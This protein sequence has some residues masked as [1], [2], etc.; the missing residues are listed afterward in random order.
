MSSISGERSRAACRRTF[1]AT[2]RSSRRTS[3]A[4]S[5]TRRVSGHSAARARP[6]QGA[7][8]AGA[9]LARH[10]ARRRRGRDRRRPRGERGRQD[11]DPARDLEHRPPRRRDPLRRQEP[12]SAR[13]GGRRSA[14]HRPPARRPRNVRRAQRLGEPPPRRIHA[15]RARQGRLR[16]GT[17]VLPVARGA[18]Q[19]AGRH[20]QRR[21]AA[22]ARARTCLHAAAAPA[23]P[24]RALARPR[25]AARHRDLPHRQG[26]E[27]AGG[28]DGA[29]GRAERAPGAP[30]LPGGVRARG[31]PRRSLRA[32]QR[33]AGARVHPPELPGLLMVELARRF[34]ITEKRKSSVS[35]GVSPP[36]LLGLAAV[37]I[38]VVIGSISSSIFAQQ[39]VAGLAQGAIFGS[40]ALALVLIYR[41][42]EVINF[43][44][45]DLAM[46]TT[47]IAYQLTLW[48]LSYWLSFFLTLLIAFVLGAVL[49]VVFIRP[50]QH[51]IIA[52][53]IVTV[54]MFILI[55]GLVTWEWGLHELQVG[56]PF[57]NA[58]YHAG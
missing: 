14:R 18:P 39:T 46:A 7:V 50:I 54:G 31:R 22:D 19:P 44:Q 13:P 16:A 17:D 26:P 53:V 24:R 6:R 25:A 40:L 15:S 49:Q 58:V 12:R 28:T 45:G 2:R 33:A 30:A 41:A 57:G 42:T 3:A 4:S 47:Y 56:A 55:V 11:D 34:G 27:R 1:S 38:F 52:V 51:S 10:H 5:R 29:R 9:G 23:P 32:E 43:A 37:A 35:T 48:G 20:A 8:W 21:R 36:V